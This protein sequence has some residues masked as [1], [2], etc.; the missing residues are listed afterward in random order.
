[1][2]GERPEPEVFEAPWQ[3]QAFAMAVT[4]NEAGV[5]AW[6]DW[7]EALGRRR[8]AAEAAGAPDDYWLCWLETLEEMVAAH[9]GVPRQRVVELA[10]AWQ[11]AAEATPHGT[12]ITLDILAQD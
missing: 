5:F 10:D 7:A 11:R 12:P 6:S 4:L 3:A 8:A 9:A 2:S 1:M